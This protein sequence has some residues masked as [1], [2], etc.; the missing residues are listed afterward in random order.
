MTAELGWLYWIG[1]M[2]VAL[3]LI[4]E[5]A[6]VHADDFS[7]VNVAF[8]TVNGVVSIVMGIATVA[9][10]LFDLQPPFSAGGAS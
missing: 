1:L 7:R 3:L 4:V 2:V 5:N 6:I 8:F 10:V 9:D